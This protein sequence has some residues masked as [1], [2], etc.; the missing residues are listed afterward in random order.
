MLGQS[1]LSLL[2]DNRS[3]SKLAQGITTEITGE[4]GSIAPQNDKTLAPLKPLLDHYKFTADWASLDQYAR[5]LE[6]QG[7]PINLG[8]YVG[9]GAGPR[10]LSSA[11]TTASP[12]P[13]N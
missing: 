11:T 7:T 2:L 9:L 8:T 10:S 3:L 5:R 12:L 4:G 6:K 1:E 13:P